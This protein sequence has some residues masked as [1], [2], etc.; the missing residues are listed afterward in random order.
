MESVVAGGAENGTAAPAERPAPRA[1]EGDAGGYRRRASQVRTSL[2]N[3]TKDA[4]AWSFMYG[5]GA[6]NLMPFLVL[7]NQ[8]LLHQAAFGGVPSLLGGI[9]QW[10]AAD[11]ADRTRRR[12]VIIVASAIVQ[13]LSWLPLC[14]AVFLA[15]EQAFWLAL[16]AYVVFT[17]TGAFSVP[18]WASLMGDLVPPRRRGRYFGMRNAL[19]G[20]VHFGSLFAAG[21]WL[22]WCKDNPDVAVLG[23]SGLNFG[24]LVIFVLSCAARCIS[25]WYLA[26]VHEPPYAPQPSDRFT[27]WAFLK[28]LPHAHFGRFVVYN[29]LMNA[30]I[31]CFTNYLG[32]YLLKQRDFSPGWFGVIMTMNLM[33]T[34]LSQ[35]YWGRL[36]DRVGNKRVLALGGIGLVATPILFPLGETLMHYLLVMTYD[37]L[38]MGAFSL[39]AGNYFYDVVTPAK[40]ARCGACN[41]LFVGTGTL[42]GCFAGALL[43]T[44]APLPLKVA[45][46]TITHAFTLILLTSAALRLL[47]N[48]LLLWSFAEFRLRRPAF[49]PALGKAG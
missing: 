13:A 3:S 18:P 45:G 31:V 48:L 49:G 46:V 11:L 23:L 27:M 10:F 7:G 22:T 17:A 19:S 33:A 37:G 30:G 41:M 20:L 32:W 4:I 39:A 26:H 38:M 34:V 42:V 15:K 16:L 6:R 9:L 47:P 36:A 21:W 24:F 8:G 5:A 28:R 25:A 35:P 40:R 29:G 14:V 44:F 1:S 2:R 12:N 43:A